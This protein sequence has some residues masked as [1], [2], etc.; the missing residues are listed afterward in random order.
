ME[1]HEIEEKIKEGWIKTWFAIEVMATSKEI[2]ERSLKEHVEK[3]SKMKDII[4]IG[5]DFKDVQKV[6]NPPK[7]V[8]E[9]YSQVVE[10]TLLARDLLALIVAIVLYAPSA[11]EILEPVEKKIKIDEMQNIANFIA[12]LIHQFASAGIG[13][14]V[15]RA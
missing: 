6:E 14:I 11:V 4:V 5:K 9:A 12:S 13:G 10:V 1:K 15:I 2:A 8:K 7:N 3:L